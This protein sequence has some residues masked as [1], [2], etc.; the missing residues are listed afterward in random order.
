MPN[1][2]KIR[3]IAILSALALIV[4]SATIVVANEL[5]KS[6]ERAEADKAYYTSLNL[7]LQEYKSKREEAITNAKLE[8]AK[9]MRE[10]EDEYLALLSQQ[11][12]LIAT[13]TRQVLVSESSAVATSGGQSSTSQKKSSTTI[14]VASAPKPVTSTRSS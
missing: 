1:K 14:K 6:Y 10:S 5:K 4:P 2:T 11:P 3:I 13:H 7:S 9:K 8:S 12:T